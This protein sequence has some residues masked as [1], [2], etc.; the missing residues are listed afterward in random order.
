MTLIDRAQ[1]LLHTFKG[2]TYVYGAGVL[3]CTGELVSALGSRAALV[4]DSF[5][6]SA[7]PLDTIRRSLAAAGVALCVEVD[8]AR[9][10]AP[11]EDLT[12][13]TDALRDVQ[14]DVVVSFGGG[15]TIDTAKAAMVLLTMGG[16]IDGYFGTGLVTAALQAQGAVLPPHVAIQTAASSASH[17]SKYSNITD[18]ARAQKKLIDRKSVV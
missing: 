1:A 16:A 11:R 4:R 2:E 17:L 5:P 9:P 13:I 7:E 12:R 8:G 18:V 6:G 3:P 15:S 14:P 10:N